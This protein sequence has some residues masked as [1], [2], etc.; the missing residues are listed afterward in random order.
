MARHD[1][2]LAPEAATE[3]DRAIALRQPYRRRSSALDK[4]GIV[5][6]RLI[7]GELDEAARL[8]H[9]AIDSV[10][11]TASDRVRKKLLTVYQRT[12]KAANIGVVT[13][14]RDRMRP[15]LATAV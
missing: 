14:L 5:E 10:E 7:E 2:S 1:R 6:A 3:I 13:D 15:L 4:L 11:A 9:L 8:G 12:E